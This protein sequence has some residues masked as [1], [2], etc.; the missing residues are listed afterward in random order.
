MEKF[1]FFSATNVLQPNLSVVFGVKIPLGL[2]ETTVDI[3]AECILSGILLG[4]LDPNGTVDT[5]RNR[6]IPG[7]R[8]SLK[9][10]AG[11]E[12][13]VA[14]LTGWSTSLPDGGMTVTGITGVGKRRY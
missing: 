6:S 10:G 9:A 7:G 3:S 1:T 2:L 5:G 14:T 13:A 12:A 11:L 4:R 8:L